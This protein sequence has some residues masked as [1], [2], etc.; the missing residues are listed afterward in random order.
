MLTYALYAYMFN[1]Y[2]SRQTG[3]RNVTGQETLPTIWGT[4]IKLVTKCQ[5]SAI[6]V[7]KKNA[8]KNILGWTEGRTELKQY[9]P[10]P[11]VERWYKN[12]RA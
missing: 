5:V 10:P 8:T 2:K 4:Y 9:T 11:P 6:V 12:Q 3:S 7:A 1:V